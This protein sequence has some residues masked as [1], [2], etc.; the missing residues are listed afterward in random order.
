MG[1]RV[2]SSEFWALRDITLTVRQGEAWGLLGDNG[3]GKSTL[4]KV[5]ARVQKPTAGRVWV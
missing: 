5:I 3:A 2:K 1:P 4:L